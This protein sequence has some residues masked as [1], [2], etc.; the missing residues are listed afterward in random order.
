M[1]LVLDKGQHSLIREKQL[2]INIPEIDV[3][4]YSIKFSSSGGILE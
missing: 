4:A 2:L 1:D 3:S